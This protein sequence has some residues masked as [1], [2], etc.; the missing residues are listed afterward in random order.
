MLFDKKLTVVRDV[1]ATAA[2]SEPEQNPETSAKDVAR[3]SQD[4]SGV[5]SM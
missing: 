1:A 2:D 3:E 5:F 4:N